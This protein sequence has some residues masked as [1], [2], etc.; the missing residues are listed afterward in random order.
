MST[1]GTSNTFSNLVNATFTRPTFAWTTS[2]TV[3]YT[4]DCTGGSSWI[5][6]DYIQKTIAQMQEK[7]EREARRQ[8][9]LLSSFE[10]VFA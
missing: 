5:N 1:Y 9:E 2:N 10:E 8:E 4:T 3:T 7:Q 6:D